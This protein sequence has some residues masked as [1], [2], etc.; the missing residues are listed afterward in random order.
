MA[1]RNYKDYVRSVFEPLAGAAGRLDLLEKLRTEPVPADRKDVQ[2]ERFKTF[3][4]DQSDVVYLPNGGFAALYQHSGGRYLAVSSSGIIA[5]DE[6]NIIKWAI[7]RDLDQDIFDECT[8]LCFAHEL[9]GYYRLADRFRAPEE[10]LN[11]VDVINDEYEYHN[12]SDLFSFYRPVLVIRIPEDNYYYNLD[13]FRITAELCCEIEPLRSAIIDGELASVLLKLAGSPAV[14]NENIFQAVTASHFRHAFL[15]LYR[16]LES[17]FY[18][19]WMVELKRVGD[20][21]TRACELKKTCRT[22]LNWREKELPSMERIFELI[23]G[24]AS[25][26]ALENESQLFK[27][28]KGGK[29]F[30]RNQLGRRIYSIRNGMVHHEDYDEPNQYKPNDVQWRILS[31]YIANVIFDI[32]KEFEWDLATA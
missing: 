29:E 3:K 24:S 12:F 14:P 25:L 6:Q 8:F 18:L 27:D 19:P 28:I 26:D 16:C 23:P 4:I 10:A 31:L 5:Q 13:I 21:T 1:S 15:E 22:A 11:V 20:I 9:K 7:A 30:S 17:I 2:F 32:S